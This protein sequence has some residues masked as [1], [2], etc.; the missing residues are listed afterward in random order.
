MAK[1]T[2]LIDCYL[3]FRKMLTSALKT[4]FK[5]LKVAIFALEIVRFWL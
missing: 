5:H 4:L 2:N 3:V 1:M